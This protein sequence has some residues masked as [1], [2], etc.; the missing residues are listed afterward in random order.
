M[1][2]FALLRSLTADTCCSTEWCKPMSTRMTLLSYVPGLY[3]TP[4]HG[5]IIYLVHM[6][7]VGLSY[8]TEVAI[9]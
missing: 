8:V 1:E 9:L 2:A 5:K 4:R 3:N 6:S 7:A